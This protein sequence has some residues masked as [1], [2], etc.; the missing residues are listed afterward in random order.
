MAALIAASVL[1][2]TRRLDPSAVYAEVDWSLLTMFAGLFVV[3]EGV[4]K[5]GL[6]ARWLAW[7]PFS[8]R[9][10]YLALAGVTAALSNVVSN[11]PAVLVLHRWAAGFAQA[12]LAWLLLAMTSTLAGNLTLVGSVANLIVVEQAR[13]VTK[14]GF[15]QY[16]K[17]GVPLTLATMGF[18]LAWLLW[19]APAVAR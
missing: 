3:V 7:L 1:L 16:A 6:I 5:A 8:A 9:G 14:V 4:E 19:I 18:G 13:G 11:V 12:R 10:S 17:L 15:W 2:I